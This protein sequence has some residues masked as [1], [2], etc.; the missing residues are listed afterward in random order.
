MIDPADSA[1]IATALAA[2]IAARHPG[3]TIA[4]APEPLG[5]GFD[6]FIFTFRLANPPDDAW[7][8][9]LVLRVYGAPTQGF[10]A[11][12]EAAAQRFVVGAG[13]PGIAPL[14]VEEEA[15]GFGLPIMVMPFI[16]GGTLLQRVTAN[17]LKTGGILAQMAALHV[18]LH[19]LP[20][21]DCPLVSDETHA[22]RQ[23]SALRTRAAPIMPAPG[24]EDALLWLE[25]TQGMALPEERSF[26]HNDFHPLNILAGTDGVLTVIDWSDATMGDRA[27]DVARTVTLLSFAYI[28]ASSAPERIILRAARGFLRSRYLA[29]YERQYPLDPARFAWWKALQ[30]V[31]GWVQLLELEHN[32][33]SGT[34]ITGAA[35]AIPPDTRDE[36]RRYATERM[37]EAERLA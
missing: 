31:T 20:I 25:R 3:A 19:R 37:R 4:G 30:S 34:A 27:C 23:M 29:P 15:P 11:M 35:A 8:G 1:Q 2:W 5:R 10:K 9:D 16:A 12:H 13:Y 26:T 7:R 14:A 32:R 18:R 17:P 22:A 28:A 24:V 36:A 6:T 21:D 33:T